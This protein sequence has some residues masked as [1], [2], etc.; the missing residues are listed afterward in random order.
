MMWCGTYVSTGTAT[1]P[2]CLDDKFN[3]FNSSAEMMMVYDQFTP[4]IQS[5]TIMW[6]SV[7]YDVVQKNIQA[8][9]DLVQSTK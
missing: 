8:K 9:Y 3:I 5:K 1:A 7:K 6:G 4:V 2:I